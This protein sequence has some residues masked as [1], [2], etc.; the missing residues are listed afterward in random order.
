M[1]R[2][3]K[4]GEA[5]THLSALLAEVEAGE[6]LVICRGTTPVAQV[7]RVAGESDHAE[8]SATLRRERARQKAVTTSEIL[9]W[10][11]EGHAR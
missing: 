3:V 8:L 1:V 11:H 5:K 9:S 10:R 4:I 6:D 2:Q 7:T